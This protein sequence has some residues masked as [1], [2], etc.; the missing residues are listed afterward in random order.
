VA[1]GL[2]SALVPL[3]GN[4]IVATFVG[5]VKTL[6]KSPEALRRMNVVSGLLLIV[7]GLGIPFF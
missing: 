1:I 2:M 3:V 4:L 6:L 7:V 5:R